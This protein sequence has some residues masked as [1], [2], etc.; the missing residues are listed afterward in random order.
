MNKKAK[1][2]LTENV[3]TLPELHASWVDALETEWLKRYGSQ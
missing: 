1:G 2:A 3:P